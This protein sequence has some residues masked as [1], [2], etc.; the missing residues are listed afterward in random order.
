MTALL[1]TPILIS[2]NQITI[3]TT[4]MDTSIPRN[5]IITYTS[6]SNYNVTSNIIRNVN[7]LSIPTI[8]NFVLSSNHCCKK[9]ERKT[10]LISIFLIVS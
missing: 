3:S 4:I 2:N 9:D 5:Y 1:N 7:I 10:F 6:S 8:T